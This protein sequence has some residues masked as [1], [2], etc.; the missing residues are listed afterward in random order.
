[1]LCKMTLVIP[2]ACYT[3]IACKQTNFVKRSC[4]SFPMATLWWSA[5]V[6]MPLFMMAMTDAASFMPTLVGMVKVMAIMILTPSLLLFLV[7]L[8]AM[9]SF[10]KTKWYW[11]RTLRMDNIRTSP[12]H[13]AHWVRARMLLLKLVPEQEMQ[14]L[15]LMQRF[16]LVLTIEWMESSIVSLD[17]W[18][19][20]WWIKKGIR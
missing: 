19:L 17:K 10:G 3:A 6:S 1:M 5:V 20:Q 18:A 12:P 8:W 4:K 16:P 11:W 2:L 9:G 13:N 15:V 14:T 7:R